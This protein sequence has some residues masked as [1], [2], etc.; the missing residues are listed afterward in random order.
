MKRKRSESCRDML[1]L[2]GTLASAGICALLLK[3][4]EMMCIESK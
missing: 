1:I 2:L 3:L 4:A